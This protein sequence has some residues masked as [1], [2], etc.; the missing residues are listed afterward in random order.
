MASKQITLTKG[1]VT[2]VDE[3]DYDWLNQWKWHYSK[4]RDT[5]Y[6]VRG[7]RIS[8]G[9]LK[10]I[11][12]HR[13]IVNPPVGMFIDHINGDRLDNRKCNLRICTNI[14]NSHNRKINNG[15]KYKGVCFERIKW[16]AYIDVNKVRIHLGMFSSEIDAAK[17]YNE[18]A[19]KYFGEF[20]RLNTV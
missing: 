20:A 6:A 19:V 9:K 18:A 5:G 17:A 1:F 16:R 14:Q 15:R 8:S 4:V 13:L 7:D 12:M 10:I 3:E 11:R 2:I